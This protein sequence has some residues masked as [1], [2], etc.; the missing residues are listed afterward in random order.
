[1]N[2]DGTE[3]SRFVR[4]VARRSDG[5]KAV[6]ERRFYKSDNQ[7]WEMPRMDL[8]DTVTN[9]LSSA[10]PR[11]EGVI[12]GPLHPRSR[13]KLLADAESCERAGFELLPGNALV[14]FEP[15]VVRRSVRPSP[16]VETDTIEETEW[17]APA[18]GCVVL[19]SERKA[20]SATRELK[21][22]HFIG[23]VSLRKTEPEASLFQIPKGYREMSPTQVMALQM[24]QEGRDCKDCDSELMKGMDQGY[25]ERK[26]K[27]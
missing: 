7:P 19:R 12:S 3:R 27:K 8:Y 6:H 14:G 18:L 1:M 17:V 25:R 4:T 24:K 2:A 5:T 9:T 15:T 11:V 23:F 13:Q 16:I 22:S 21:W 10:Y 20:F 26:A